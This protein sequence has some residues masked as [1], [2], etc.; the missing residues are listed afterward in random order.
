MNATE[1]R[2]LCLNACKVYH[3]YLEKTG[4]GLNEVEV[5]GV[6]VVDLYQRIVSIRLSKKIFDAEALFFRFAN[7]PKQYDGGQIEVLEYDTERNILYVQ[8]K[9]AELFAKLNGIKNADLLVIADMKFLVQ[10]VLNWFEQKGQNLQLPD[11][12]SPLDRPSVSFANN[13]GLQPAP[14]QLQAIRTVITKPFSYIWGAPGTGKTQMVLANVVIQYARQG[15]RCAILAPT[16]TALEQVMKGVLRISDAAGIPRNKFLRLG[17]TTKAF[18]ELYPEVCESHGIASQR[19]QIEKQMRVLK[20]AMNKDTSKKEDDTTTQLDEAAE[21]LKQVRNLIALVHEKST[22]QKLIKQMIKEAQQ[23]M[24]GHPAAKAM[25]ENIEAATLDNTIS[26]LAGLVEKMRRDD[27]L[28]QAK[29]ADYAIMP[30]ADLKTMHDSLQDAHKRMVGSNERAKEAT[31]IAATLDS[32][33]HRFLEDELEVE[34]IFLDEAGY[35]NAI[36]AMVLMNGNIPVT[37]LGDHL[38]L[39][40]VCEMNDMDLQDKEQQDAF[41]WSKSAI[42]LPRL[43]EESKDTAYQAYLNNEEQLSR[44]IARA[45][46]RYTHRFGDNLANIL[47]E[48]VYR[49][50]FA[51]DSGKGETEIFYVHVDT[52]VPQFRNAMQKPTRE[53]EP[54][55]LAIKQFIQM[56]GLSDYAILTPYTNQVKLLAKILTKERNEGRILTVHGAQGKEWDNVLISVVDTDKKWFTDTKFAKTRGLHLINTAVSRAKRRVIIFCNYPFWK[57]QNGQLIKGLL[58]VAEEWRMF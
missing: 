30:E 20:N 16:N 52:P 6:E 17:H 53:S 27:A 15:K 11:K 47:N 7:D 18:A 54:E 46:L 26:F 12:S 10:R 5:W 14:D 34:H 51:S 43:F 55:A 41:I 45:D 8:P 24:K 38:Q 2:D 31:V 35:A 57:K 21:K 39:P 32:Y 23:L 13:L 56:N 42:H 25:A 40:P 36:K 58:D 19:L 9:S 50:G 48:H 4:K 29:A 28:L 22:S 1:I 33:I 37:F 49:N 44:S 3:N